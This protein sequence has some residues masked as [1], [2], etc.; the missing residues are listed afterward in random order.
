MTLTA[1]A[2]LPNLEQDQ[3]ALSWQSKEP[4]LLVGV[5]LSSMKR[6]RQF[7]QH[8]RKYMELKVGSSAQK[9]YQQ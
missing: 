7:W 9:R 3:L 6:P 8:F 4:L 5:H 1:A 2:K